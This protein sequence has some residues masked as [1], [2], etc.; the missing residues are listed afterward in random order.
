[1]H[2]SVKKL[3]KKIAPKKY[4]KHCIQCGKIEHSSFVPKREWQ[5]KECIGD[6]R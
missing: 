3:M 4:E 1:M 5:C 6:N 2:P